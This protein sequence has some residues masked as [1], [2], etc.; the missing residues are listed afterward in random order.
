[1]HSAESFLDIGSGKGDTIVHVAQSTNLH[2]IGIE[3]DPSLHLEA[4]S[5]TK[6]LERCIQDRITLLNADILT[7]SKAAN[8]VYLCNTAFSISF[9]LQLSRWLDAH[10]EIGQIFSLRPLLNIQQYYLR[11]RFM[12]SC[13]WDHALCYEYIPLSEDGRVCKKVINKLMSRLSWG[14]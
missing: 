2:S 6:K 13:T 10:K 12:V 3:I 5:A 11:S 14:S 9:Q 8:I 4:L 7:A 1:M